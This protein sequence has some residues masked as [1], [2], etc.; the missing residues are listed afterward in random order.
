M[1]FG[2]SATSLIVPKNFLTRL[3][4]V[5]V[6][7]IFSLSIRFRRAAR[8]P[9]RTA[10]IHRDHQD[11]RRDRP[12]LCDSGLTRTALLFTSHRDRIGGHERLGGLPVGNR[13]LLVR[14]PRVAPEMPASP[15]NSWLAT[16]TGVSF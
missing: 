12:F 6:C 16:L 15:T 14:D 7:A 10:A 8:A 2:I 9:L 5:N 3:R 13:P 11:R 4:P 1:R